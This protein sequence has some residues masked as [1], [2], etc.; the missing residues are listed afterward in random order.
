MRD[1][2][3]RRSF[4]K[5]TTHTAIG[6]IA[7]STATSADA[8]P[9][10]QSQGKSLP[11]TV[12]SYN[13]HYGEGSDGI[14]NLQR[15]A[16]V[17]RKSDADLV[18]LQEVDNE[19]SSRSEFVFQAQQ[20][21]ESLGMRYEY[22]PYLDRE[23]R[24]GHDRQFGNAILSKRN[25]P[26]L[27]TTN[28][29]LPHIDYEDRYSVQRGLLESRINVKGEKVWFYSTHL[30]LTAEQR[31][32]QT[33]K[34]AGILKNREGTRILLGDFNAFPESSAIETITASYTDVF[35]ALGMDQ[36]YT[37]PA[38]YDSREPDARIDYIFVSEDV[39]TRNAEVLQT[40]ASDH[41]PLVAD[42][43]VPRSKRE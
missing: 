22:G 30:G 27:E 20:L 33:E 32:Q 31:R 18:G 36:A 35:A 10:D 4:L 16:D 29:T 34:I 23:N 21:A 13:I 42:L 1:N 12:M 26:I 37:Y 5:I 8:K 7:I 28:Y 43:T 24:D 14:L 25:L 40:F 17:I 39:K 19:W 3:S 6:G 15:I 9:I 11:L 41:L 38:P 2:H